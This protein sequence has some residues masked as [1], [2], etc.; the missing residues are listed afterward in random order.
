[1]SEE[2]RIVLETE[3]AQL[4]SRLGGYFAIL[5]EASDVEPLPQGR[6]TRILCSVNGAPSFHCGIQPRGEGKGYIMISKDRKRA[7]NLEWGQPLIAVIAP[8]P[9]PLGA[10]MPEVLEAL[11]EQD[12]VFRREFETWT[13]GKKRSLIFGMERM[14][15]PDKQVAFA[16]DFVERR[17]TSQGRFG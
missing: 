1:M 7:L 15:N 10:P 6:K 9:S 5:L 3:L 12:D 14:K 17:A 16:Y 4:E 13:P 2:I 8:D 11:L